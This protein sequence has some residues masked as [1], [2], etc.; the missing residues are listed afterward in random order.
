MDRFHEMQAFVAVV[1]H[2]SF[3][4]AAEAL[5]TSKAAMSR[6]VAEL[7]QR[8]GVRLL[9]RTTRRL[10]LTD[11]GK[12]FH[13]RC[14]DLLGALQEAESE[15]TT[16]S[17]EAS[18][19]LRVSAPVTFGNVH[20]AP[21]WGDYLQQHPKVQL[22]LSLSDRTVDL[23]EEGIDLAIRIAR[24]PHPTLI[25]RKL[26]TTRVVPCASPAYLARRGT[27]ACPQELAAHDVIAYTYWSLKDEWEFTA[28]DGTVEKVK[29]RPKMYAN[30]GDTCVAVAL[31]HQGIVMQPDF[32]VYEAL[33]AGTLVELLPGYQAGELGI[34]AVYT[35]RRQLSLKLRYLV[36]FLAGAFEAPVWSAR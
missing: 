16:R 17:G 30:S 23:V 31:R 29:T 22:D 9:N 25:A 1:E 15:L 13:V 35:S 26:A 21:L 24:A 6:Q 8:L 4:G 18:G 2:G 36:D 10:S 3:V 28:P 11:E 7:E 5:K 20:L 32:L 27:P 34:Y 14:T 19:Q 33:R 12:L